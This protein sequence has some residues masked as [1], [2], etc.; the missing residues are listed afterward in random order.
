VAQ[1]LPC[2]PVE[3]SVTLGCSISAHTSIAQG[4]QARHPDKQSIQLEILQTIH[5]R[6]SFFPKQSIRGLSQ[7][8]TSHTTLK[9]VCGNFRL[10]TRK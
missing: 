10:S 4:E 6:E 8:H 3:A 2:A 9:T 7:L 5:T 1:W